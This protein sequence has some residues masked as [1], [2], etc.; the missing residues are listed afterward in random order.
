MMRGRRQLLSKLEYGSRGVSAD[1]LNVVGMVAP[2][3]LREVS[4]CKRSFDGY[5]CTD[6]GDK[7]AQPVS[8]CKR[9][10]CPSC[11]EVRRGELTDRSM[12][13]WS[14]LERSLGGLDV[15]K[16]EV[17]FPPYV[18]DKVTEDNFAKLG[19]L[20]YKALTDCLVADDMVFAGC[21]SFHWW[22][23]GNPVRGF[24][25]HIHL[26]LVNSGFD[27]KKMKWRKF[28]DY[29]DVNEFRRRWIKYASEFLGVSGK[30]VWVVHYKYRPFREMTHRMM[31][32][33][34]QPVF[35]FYKYIKAH[36][37]FCDADIPWAKRMLFGRRKLSKHVVW[38]G[39]LANGVRSR[40]LGYLNIKVKSLR[41]W[42]SVRKHVYGKSEC[43]RCGGDLVRL[44]GC[45]RMRIEDV[46]DD[47][48]IDC[49]SYGSGRMR[50]SW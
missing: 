17:T 41:E 32:M 44:T 42:M 9:L 40:Y 46:P 49:F 47:M 10:V 25:P 16:G 21:I 38:Y 27:K 11:A 6:C 2:E 19:N 28:M 30:R 39:A 18:R 29:I 12:D 7:V 50:V 22:H 36:G 15:L 8:C 35:D 13:I 33:Y 37:Q 3:L 34:R 26:T 48:R 20:A 31:Y 45:L 43:L 14:E 5:V 23:S 1:W 4:D 24:F